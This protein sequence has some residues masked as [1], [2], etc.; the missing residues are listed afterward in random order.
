MNL[1]AFVISLP[2]RDDRRKEFEA[3]WKASECGKAID[4]EYL[5]AVEVPAHIGGQHRVGLCDLACAISHRKAVAMAQAAGLEAVIVFEDDA[6]PRNSEKL[7]DFLFLTLPKSTSGWNTVNLGGCSAQ[8]R[9]ATPSLRFERQAP[10]LFR[11]RGMVTT[12]AI[13]YHRNVYDDILAA[14][15]TEEEFRLTTGDLVTTRPYDQWLG[16]HG[17]MLTGE[18]PYFVQSGSTSDILGGPHNCSVS[19]LIEKTYET[20]RNSPHV[21]SSAPS[22][23]GTETTA[24]LAQH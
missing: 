1:R 14:V 17:V 6:I 2:K 19:D 18:I 12:H 23:F 8:W 10:G 11:V 20:L 16:S 13:L 24:S 3:A 21:P 9:P 5:P 7:A 22:I 15:P 4:W